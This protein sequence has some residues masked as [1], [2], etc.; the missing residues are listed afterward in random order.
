VLVAPDQQVAVDGVTV[1]A[2]RLVNGASIRAEPAGADPVCVVLQLEQARDVLVG[3]LACATGDA[4]PG[5]P[6]GEVLRLWRR[7]SFVDDAPEAPRGGL[8]GDIARFDHDGVAGWTLDPAHPDVPVPLEVLADGRVIA[9]VVAD[10]RR[11]D[12]AMRGIGGGRCGFAQRFARPLGWRR[13]QVVEVRRAGDGA[14][15]PGSPRLL[16]AAARGTP[17]AEQLLAAAIAGAAD[18]C[19][20]SR[21]AT[22]LAAVLESLLRLRVIGPD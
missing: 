9:R 12:L 11:P 10:L 14:P 1:A 19:G 21:L 7:L 6:E 18:S 15:V 4:R 17:E 2:A 20:R 16:P 22:E 13:D 8:L 3:G 5:S